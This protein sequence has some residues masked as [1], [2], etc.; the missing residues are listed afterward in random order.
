MYVFNTYIYT[1]QLGQSSIAREAEAGILVLSV[2]EGR[3]FLFYFLLCF[4]VSLAVINIESVF[5]PFRLASHILF[6]LK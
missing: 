3:S 2:L 5:F 1:P 6:L 4:S